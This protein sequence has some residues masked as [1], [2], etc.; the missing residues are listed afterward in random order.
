MWIQ[1][2]LSPYKDSD[3]IVLGCT[4]FPFA[5]KVIQ[6]IMGDDTFIVDGGEGAARETKH[7]LEKSNLLSD[8][9]E[10]G[11]V[12]FEN[13]RNTKEELELSQKLFNL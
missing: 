5:K 7:L 11:S 2:L 12:K 8:K 10:K 1:K 3:S 6:K 4:H 13:S 9:T